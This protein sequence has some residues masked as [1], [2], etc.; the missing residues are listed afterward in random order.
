MRHIIYAFAILLAGCGNVNKNNSDKTVFRYNE[1]FGITSLDPAFSNNQSNIWACNHLFN[2][3]VQLDDQLNPKPAI[4]KSW[5]ISD[6]GKTYL[7][8]LRDDVYFQKDTL[9]HPNRKIIAS[10][11]V[12]SFNRVTNEKT[13]SPGAWIFN[14]VK[15]DSENNLSG[16]KALN[17]STL[18]ISLTT[19]F[20]PFLGLLS[21]AYCSVVP[22]EVVEFYGKDFRKHPIGTGPFKFDR[23]IERTALVLHKNENYF[24]FD[25]TGKRLPYLDAVMISFINDKQSAFLEF[26]KGKL[27]L[28]S[29]LDAGF[30]DD[31]LTPGGKM[32][33]KYTGRF[34]METAPYL[35]TEYLGFIMDPNLESVRGKP[36]NNLKIRQAISY[37]FDRK[38]MIAYLRNSMAT[39]GTGGIIPP[40]T[41]GFTNAETY[42]YNYNPELAKKLLAEAGYPNGKGLPTITMS[43]TSSY[44]DLCEYIQGQLSEIG[45]KVNVEINQSA[46][47]RQMVAKQQLAW[48]RASWIADY[49]DGENYLSLFYS[50][51]KAPAGPNYTHYSNK[52]FDE[53]YEQSLLTQNNSM[54][55]EL[56]RAMDKTAMQDAPVVILYYDRVLRLVQNK[57]SGLTMNP[58]NLLNLK[59]VK[60][61]N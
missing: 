15:K 26:L 17:D 43:T 59:T 16:V 36:L 29:G 57:V 20:P 56:Y 53:L 19:P 60:I 47:H 42:G 46:Q 31:L 24:E 58:L 21:A 6:D 54:R 11:F 41:P 13:A 44:Q 40:G 25:S 34:R 37:G 38:K 9:L 2:G 10:D 55:Q 50:K 23:W 4:A 12:Y 27:D 1:A 48:F 8:H 5:E 52:H 30:K 3:L 49:A 39:P 51:N 28:I 32:R 22:H 7:F 45:I 35:N 14:F 18:E 33:A 61:K